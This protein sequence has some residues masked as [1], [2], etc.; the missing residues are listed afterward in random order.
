MRPDFLCVLHLDFRPV[1]ESDRDLLVPVH[2]DALDHDE[3]SLSAPKA[4]IKVADDA[5]KQRPT[6]YRALFV[7]EIG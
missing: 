6:S 3:Q 4:A 2:H 7:C 5:V 1:L